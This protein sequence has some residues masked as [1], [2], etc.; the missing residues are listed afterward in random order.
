MGNPLICGPKANNCSTL[1]EPLSFPPDAL[2]GVNDIY[3]LDYNC[4]LLIYNNC[5]TCFDVVILVLKP[6]QTV[7]KRA[8]MWQLLLVQVLVL[9]LL[10]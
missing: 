7:V 4:Q 8:N 10:S 1:P 9:L 6:N 5:M 2:R 3:A